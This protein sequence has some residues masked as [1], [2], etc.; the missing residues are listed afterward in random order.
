MPRIAIISDVH[1]DIQSL[2]KALRMIDLEKCDTIV[3]LGDITGY[4]FLRGKYEATRDLKGCIEIIRRNCSVV[5]PGNH[6]LFHLKRIPAY[7][8]DTLLTPDW[9]DL[10]DDEK[11]QKSSGKVWNYSDDYP[12]KMD[13]QDYLYLSSLP[14]YTIRDY[15]DKKILFSHHVFPDFTGMINGFSDG[16]D[17]M[18]KHINFLIRHNCNMSISG[19][20]HIEGLGIYYEQGEGILSQLFGGFDYFSFGERKIKNKVCAVSIPALADNGQVN[21]FAIL[22]TARQTV[23]SISLNTNRKFIL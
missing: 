21:G 23:R 14:E 18:K 10:P 19:H 7:N 4:P 22:D 6:D 13:E 9:Y 17:R 11:L 8:P 15:G 20:M 5:A 2:K 1:E 16:K 3:C 12:I